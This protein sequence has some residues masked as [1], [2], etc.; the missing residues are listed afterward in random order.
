MTSDRSRAASVPL[1][2]GRPVLDL[3]NTVS[4]RG[5]LARA[6]DH[7]HQAEDALV[8]AVRAGLLTAAEA[9]AL[10]EHVAHH[11][12]AGTELLAG[13]RSLR[14]LVSDAVLDPAGLRTAEVEPMVLEALAHSHLVPVEGTAAAGAHRWRVRDLDEHTVRRRLVLDLLDLLTTPHGRLG[15]CA[16]PACGWVF[17]D[18]SRT[19]RRQWCSSTDCGNRNRV[20][21]HQRR[22]ASAAAAD[23]TDLGGTG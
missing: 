17:L 19:Q 8:W 13:L 7:L 15:T 9:T 22:R 16:D 5:D 6:Q 18:T 1:V 3:V 23:R 4:W 20:R 11:S 14:T 10:R 2:G 21:Q 12:A